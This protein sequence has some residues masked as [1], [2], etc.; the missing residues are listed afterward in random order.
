M[1]LLRIRVAPAAA[2]LGTILLAAVACAWAESPVTT[3]ELVSKRYDF[4]SDVELSVDLVTPA[5]LRVDRVRFHMP[6]PLDGRLTRS[7][8]LVSAEVAVS[9]TAAEPLKAG[10]GIALFDED[11][12]L[13]AVAGGGSQV[14]P[15][16]G[17]R[18]Q[19]FTLI[20]D[21]VN[22]EA[23]KAETFQISVESKP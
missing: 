12:R 23:H 22:A 14:T 2:G 11:G 6:T 17:E 20:F 8:G 5:G 21:G 1:N 13:L 3:G 4:R 19:T 16:K 9:N 7:A 10:L 18:Q 15:I